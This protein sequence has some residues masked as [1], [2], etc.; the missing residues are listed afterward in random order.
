M[1]R[2]PTDKTKYKYPA[3][4]PNIISGEFTSG[5]LSDFESKNFSKFL[6]GNR[7]FSE[8]RVVGMNEIF[9]RIIHQKCF[10]CFIQLLHNIHH[11]VSLLKENDGN[12]SV[13]IPKCLVSR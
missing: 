2:G 6:F 11:F 5:R 10:V 8:I 4:I 1:N 12:K 9:T 13:A 7:F 3:I